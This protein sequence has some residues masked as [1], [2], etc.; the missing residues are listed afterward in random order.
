MCAEGSRRTRK[1]A[2]S[3]VSRMAAEEIDSLV[4]L[5]PRGRK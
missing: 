4:S 1:P 5:R 3:K 2:S